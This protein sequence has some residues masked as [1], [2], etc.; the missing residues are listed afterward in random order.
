[1]VDTTARG[2]VR[3]AR[4]VE[5]LRE[6]VARVLE[7][8]DLSLQSLEVFELAQPVEVLDLGVDGLG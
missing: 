2:F 3:S 8:E 7:A 5:A 6:D 4:D 1:M